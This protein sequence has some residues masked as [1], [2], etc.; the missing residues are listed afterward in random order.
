MTHGKHWLFSLA[1][2]GATSGAA[3]AQQQ[4]ADSD[5]PPAATPPTPHPQGRDDPAATPG[6]ARVSET[7]REAVAG[8]EGLAVNVRPFGSFTFRTDLRD[9][10]GDVAISRAGAR[11]TFTSPIGEQAR[12][13]VGVAGEA[14][15][16][17]FKNAAGLV[18]GTSDPFDDVYKLDAAPILFFSQSRELT[19][20][21]GGLV[22]VAGE[23]GVDIG[24]AITG[25]G[26][27]GIRY[28]ISENFALSLG[29]A[30]KTRLEENVLVIPLI[31]FELGRDS[32]TTFTLDGL[33]A[34]LTTELNQDTRFFIEGGWELRDYRLEDD[35]PLASGVVHDIRVP[36]GAGFIWA[37]SK[38]ASVELSGGAIVWQRFRFD[39]SNGN[40]VGEEHTDPAPFV[41][42]MATFTF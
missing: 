30:V 42:L 35:S 18:P 37:P 9:G 19:W 33:T 25:G 27:G 13:S 16:Y 32:K 11:V 4:P 5:Q 38:T 26:L 6:A 23:A 28:Y 22:E 31:G 41:K 20:F 2:T 8:K 15:W 39:D 21:V 40:R 1:L 24:D 29:V 3:F 7:T 10:E 14:S 36:V 17:D 34:R 12:L